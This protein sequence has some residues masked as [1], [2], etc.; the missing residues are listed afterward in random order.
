[1]L[2]K[3]MR[4]VSL[5]LSV[6]L[7]AGILAPAAHA[8]PAPDITAGAAL[9]MDAEHDEVL[10]EKNAHQKMYPASLTKVMTALL[11]LEAIDAGQ[12]TLD[13]VVTAST[14]FSEGLSIYGSSQNIK[15]GE[16]LSVRDLLY[17][18]LV[19]S[20]NEAGNILAQEVSGT[21]AAFVEQMNQ[22]AA[23]L[24]CEGTHFAN[25]HGLHDDNHY[26][27][28]HD[29]YLI[30]RAA[31]END[32]FRTIVATKRHEIP[33]TNLSDARVFYSTNALLV[34]WHY[35]ESYL[36]DK[37]IGIKTGTTD[38]GGYCLLSAAED[39]DTYLICVVLNAQVVRTEG[40]PTDRRQFSESKALLQ[41]GF[42]NF[43]R[44]EVVDTHKPLAQVAVTLSKTD[45]VL[46]RPAAQ[47]ECTLP[48]DTDVSAIKQEVTLTA[49]TV[50][51][52]VTEGQVLG[53]LTLTHGDKLLGT[54]DL[55]AVSG[56]ERSVFLYRLTQI[57]SFFSNP[58]FK[59]LGIVVLAIVLILLVRVVFMRP[60]R[61]YR[62]R[63]RTAYRRNYTGRRRR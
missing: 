39:E 49:E 13:Q 26:T 20:A 52:P 25:A 55:V 2:M 33:A 44:V 4:V 8:A 54:V 35:V 19:A 40:A 22:R 17:C 46:V 29:I 51:A 14:T 30:A 61:R 9:L 12:L 6:L 5:L 43:K 28:A 24:G 3:K 50:E 57:K 16:Q 37:A 11:V 23:Q 53:S 18:L 15:A 63:R 60:R 36:Y 21:T 31:M 1:M 32:T 59:L 41:W 45:H 47:L 42:S 58:L 62:S 48:V 38:E 27:T 34:T 10:F 7:M 56:A